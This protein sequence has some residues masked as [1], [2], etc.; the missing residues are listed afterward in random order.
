M[1]T[2]QAVYENGVFRPLVPVD[3]PECCLVE[4]TPTLIKRLPA[5][6]TDIAEIYEVLP[7]R[8]DTG[9]VDLAERHNEH[10]P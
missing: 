8:F 7:R 4:F 3:L 2:I 9:I 10:Q 5:D 6:G 1:A